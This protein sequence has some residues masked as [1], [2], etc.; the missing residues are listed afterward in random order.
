MCGNDI[1]DEEIHLIMQQNRKKT[2]GVY[3]RRYFGCKHQ[4]LTQATNITHKEK[5]FSRRIAHIIEGKAEGARH[6]EMLGAFMRG[7]CLL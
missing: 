6:P 5:G 4:N 2:W 1:Y 7:L 3:Q